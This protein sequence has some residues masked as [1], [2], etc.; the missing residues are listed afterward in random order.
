MFS[1]FYT[2]TF[3]G[4]IVSSDADTNP[5]NKETVYQ[6]LSGAG[7]YVTIDEVTGDITVNRPID[8]EMIGT[9]SLKV[10]AENTRPGPRVELKSRTDVSCATCI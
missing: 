10:E 8:R 1:F 2:G 3:I 6:I 7:G 9:L 5:D 4:K